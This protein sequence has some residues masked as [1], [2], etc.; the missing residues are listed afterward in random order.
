MKLLRIFKPVQ[1]NFYPWAC[2]E[3]P[4]KYFWKL[5]FSYVLFYLAACFAPWGDLAI[6]FNVAFLAAH[7][8][9]LKYV[10]TCIIR[11]GRAKY[12][13]PMERATWVPNFAFTNTGIFFPLQLAHRI[14]KVLLTRRGGSTY[15]WREYVVRVA[16]R[17]QRLDK[18]A[19]LKMYSMHS[20]IYSGASRRQLQMLRMPE[21]A[22]KEVQ[23]LWT[24]Q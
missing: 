21:A 14:S 13:A 3:L 18:Q 5:V 17:A 22:V 11:K 9:L 7:I 24:R 16:S 4:N 23:Q 15:L 20:R 8:Y 12:T 1:Y 2:I 6:T 19:W 10:W